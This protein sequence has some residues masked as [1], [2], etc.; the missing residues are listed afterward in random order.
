[1]KIFK[2]EEVNLNI[3]SVPPHTGLIHFLAISTFAGTTFTELVQRAKAMQSSKALSHHEIIYIPSI[4]AM[5]SISL[6]FF[7]D[8]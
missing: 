3:I 6:L 8:A 5:S 4:L 1:L 2:K 7:L